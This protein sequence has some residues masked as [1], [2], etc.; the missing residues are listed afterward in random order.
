M[1]RSIYFLVLLAAGC[2]RREDASP[3]T[4]V[5]SAS[6]ERPQ[7]Q[8]KPAA[9]GRPVIVAFG[10][11]LTAG[12]GLDPG[13]FYTDY[14]QKELDRR[15]YRYRVINLG[16]SGDTTTGG[17]ARIASATALK[18]A[19]TILELGG[20]DGLRGLPLPETRANLEKMTAALLESGSQVLIAGMTLPLNYGRDYI[21]DF[22]KIYVDIANQYR[23]PRI[24]FFLEG[25]A[26]ET[27]LM[28][29]DQIH[30]TA[31]GAKKVAE[32]TLK[33]LEPL[34]EKP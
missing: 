12:Y 3:A 23:I 30:P 21:R 19:I 5:P 6:A 13:Q 22:E 9:D 11:S 7:A 4:E 28:Q 33:A 10:D 26:L 18:P 32:N 17:L 8:P 29:R 24:N 16:V 14:L 1:R 20:N 25:V 2:A 34:L 27:G 31:T 15:G